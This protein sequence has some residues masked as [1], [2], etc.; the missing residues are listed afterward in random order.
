[1]Y[2]HRWKY[3]EQNISEQ[4]PVIYEKGNNYGQVGL[5]LKIYAYFNIR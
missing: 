3:T 5:S 2:E 4:N 1:M